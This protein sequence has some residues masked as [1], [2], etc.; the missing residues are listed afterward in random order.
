MG[1]DSPRLM[2]PL[3]EESK[4]RAHLGDVHGAL[5]LGLR[6]LAL[7]ERALGSAHEGL[8]DI[9]YGIFQAH[10]ELGDTAAA[11]RVLERIEGLDGS[12]TRRAVQRGLGLQA[13]ARLEMAVGRW[14]VARDFL[15]RALVVFG[16]LPAD[17]STGQ[18]GSATLIA[19]LAAARGHP[20]RALEHLRSAAEIWRENMPEDALGRARLE[21]RIAELEFELDPSHAGDSVRKLRAQIERLTPHL[22]ESAPTLWIFR[23][24]LAK[25]LAADGQWSAA[26]SEFVSAMAAYDPRQWPQS[27]RARIGADWRARLAAGRQVE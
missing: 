5:E 1:T 24:S 25:A 20:E 8:A 11:R 12:R 10:L 3:N 22:P 21:R 18:S 14:D 2:W 19:E 17:Q 9:L 27:H 13:R 26:R 6:S 15:A 23:H 16:D 7:G 4:I